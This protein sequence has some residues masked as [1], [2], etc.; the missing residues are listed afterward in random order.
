MG[1]GEGAFLLTGTQDAD[2]KSSDK[3]Q[4]PNTVNAMAS[5]RQRHQRVSIGRFP[6]EISWL[7]FQGYNICK[8][9]ATLTN[10][11]RAELPS[12]LMTIWI[13]FGRQNYRQPALCLK[14]KYKH[15]Q[16]N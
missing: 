6:R 1:Q 13:G 15:L 4:F 3:K 16:R 8:S 5:L 11:F 10:G 14:Q 9:H 7:T 2:F 12:D